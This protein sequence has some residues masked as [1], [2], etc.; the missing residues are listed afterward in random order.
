[1]NIKIPSNILPKIKNQIRIDKSF[2][3]N[4]EK[5]YVKNIEKSYV[6]NVENIPTYKKNHQD[7]MVDYYQSIL[8]VTTRYFNCMDE[9]YKNKKK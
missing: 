4:V 5:S 3:K 6:K 9:Y 7:F 2:V 8:P 1:M